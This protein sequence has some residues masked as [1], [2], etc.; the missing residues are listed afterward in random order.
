MIKKILEVIKYQMQL[1]KLNVAMSRGILARSSRVL[2]NDD[3]ASWEFGAFS[4]NGEDGIVDQLLTQI[5]VEKNRYFIEI[6]ASN[7][8]GNN[9]AYLAMVLGYKGIMI[10]GNPAGVQNIKRIYGKFNNGIEGIALFTG[11][12]E[13]IDLILSK[14]WYKDPDFFSLD[15]DGMDYYVAKKLFD[16]GLSP[17]IVSVEVNAS[18]GPDECITILPDENFN[19]LVPGMNLLY[20]GVSIAGWRKFFESRG[21]QF[22]GFESSGVNAF[23]I[24]KDCFSPDFLSS[25][26]NKGISFAMSSWS[27]K[28]YGLDWKNHYDKVKHMQWHTIEG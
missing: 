23:F 26:N 7:G 14:S 15:I 1:S 17:K 19:R 18:L 25:I 16:K 8:I 28:L 22:V 6:G 21:Y 4:E 12:D 24:K 3:P 9:S 10:D 5:T 13:S 11:S 20:F 27:K 2:K